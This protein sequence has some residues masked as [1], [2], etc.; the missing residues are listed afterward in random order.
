MQGSRKSDKQCQAP[1]VDEDEDGVRL[2]QLRT[3]PLELEE[4][5]R[6]F[7]SSIDMVN[8][9]RLDVEFARQGHNRGQRSLQTLLSG[10]ALC[11][12]LFHEFAHVLT[13]RL[14]DSMKNELQCDEF[15]IRLM[16][17]TG[18]GE[19]IAGVGLGL[20]AMAAYVHTSVAE[21]GVTHPHP[22]ERLK[23]YMSI[24]DEGRA[25][26]NR[27]QVGAYLELFTIPLHVLETAD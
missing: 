8:G 19:S 10:A 12:V 3:R 23:Q 26:F 13:T 5:A 1:S 17:A 7:R 4:A 22:M 14:P 27:T 2:V 15:G 6:I 16:I 21:L 9:E 20:L 24:L 25:K 11:F 18:N